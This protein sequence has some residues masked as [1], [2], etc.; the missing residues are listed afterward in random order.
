M[1]EHRDNES[2]IDALADYLGD[3]MDA[4]ARQQFEAALAADESLAADATS[5]R[6]A[7]DAMKSLRAPAMTIPA[8]WQPAP[9]ARRRIGPVLFRY[10][11]AALL[12]FAFGYLLRGQAVAPVAPAPEATDSLN[13]IIASSAS[14]SS[15][16]QSAFG[17]L[18]Q[19]YAGSRS[20][21]SLARSLAALSAISSADRQRSQSN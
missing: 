6:A 20:D 9:T 10:A 14:S 1:N 4:E 13:S 18:A 5:L 8:A 3:E 17:R 21:S 16:A 15:D 11:A 12:A 7:L 2:L 19:A